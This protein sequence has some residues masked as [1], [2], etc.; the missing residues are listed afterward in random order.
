MGELK[1]ILEDIVWRMI[2]EIE[3]SKEGRLSHEQKIEMAAYV[4]N[5]MRPLYTTSGRGFVYMLQKYDSDPQF[6]AD[7][8]VLIS[9]ALK[10]VSR[11]VEKGQ[12][13]IQNLDVGQW[14]YFFPRIYGRVL[15]GRTMAPIEEGEV[16]LL[17]DGSI[18]PSYYAKWYNPY[19]IRSDE[20][21]WYAFAPMPLVASEQKTQEFTFVLRVSTSLCKHEYSFVLK[22]VPR[23]WTGE[24]DE[25]FSEIFEVPDIYI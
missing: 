14:Y 23:D 7:I 5:R 24:E 20:G 1:N 11:S 6:L 15:D 2:E 13:T 9:Q 10:I 25:V 22:V 21:G 8:L 18:Q 17:R 4:L 12:E 16:I 19:H 3:E